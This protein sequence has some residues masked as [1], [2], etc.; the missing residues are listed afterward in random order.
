M[1]ALTSIIMTCFNSTKFYTHMTMEAIANITKFTDPD[2][3]ELIVID[4]T[5]KFP[6]R[7]DYH[8][9]KIDQHYVLDTDPGYPACMNMGARY[10]KGQYLVFIQNDVFVHEGW[11]PGLRQY[12][13]SGKYGV[14]FPDQVPR[15]RKYVLETYKRHPFD[16][17]SMKGGRDAGLLMITRDAFNQTGGWDEKLS[18]LAEKAFYDAMGRCGISWTDTNKVIIT[19]IMA[20][21]NLGHEPQKYDTMMRRDAGVLNV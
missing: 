9:L 18:I 14:V 7:D 21:T 1:P 8:L 16:P 5:P 12:L 2:E 15:D 6:I 4:P 3:Y 11:L 19:H 17:E 13:E 20:A 10:A